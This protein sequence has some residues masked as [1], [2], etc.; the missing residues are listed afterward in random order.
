MPGAA[1]LS[2][3]S[4]SSSNTIQSDPGWVAGTDLGQLLLSFIEHV[5]CL[6]L[7]K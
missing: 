6:I 5:D 3:F 7:G 4:S 2:L 1:M